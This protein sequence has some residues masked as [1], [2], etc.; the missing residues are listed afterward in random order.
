M[1]KYTSGNVVKYKNVKEIYGPTSDQYI[2]FTG[3]W[4]HCAYY[5]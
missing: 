1:L 2:T 3:M 4:Q 5:P